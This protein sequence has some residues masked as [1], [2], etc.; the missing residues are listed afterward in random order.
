[1]KKKYLLLSAVG[2]VITLSIQGQITTHELPESFKKGSSDKC[3]V[4]I[5]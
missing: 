1:M 5:M 4:F 2:L 3:V